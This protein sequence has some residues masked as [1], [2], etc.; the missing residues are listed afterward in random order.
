MI[1]SPPVLMCAFK[2][3]IDDDASA[4]STDS[5][6]LTSLNLSLICLGILQVEANESDAVSN[7]I[8]NHSDL[9]LA[10]RRIS[11]REF[12]KCGCSDTWFRGL[13]IGPERV[14]LPSWK[15]CF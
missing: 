8:I 12:W 3:G 14:T 2:D 15:C 11:Q 10:D 1:E 6:N 9:K 7:G 4:A 5:L 13:K